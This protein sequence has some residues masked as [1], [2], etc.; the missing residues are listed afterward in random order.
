MP[1][2]IVTLAHWRLDVLE[3]LP[4]GIGVLAIMPVDIGLLTMGLIEN[5]TSRNV[6]LAILPIYIGVLAIVPVGIGVLA[7]G[8]SGDLA[9]VP[10]KLLL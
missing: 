2:N 4:S 8:H 7:M 1:Y 5:T 3:I 6:V 10:L 9:K